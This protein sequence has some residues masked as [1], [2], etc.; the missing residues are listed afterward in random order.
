MVPGAPYRLAFSL[1]DSE[2]T[3]KSASTSSSSNTTGWDLTGTYDPSPVY[4]Y[5]MRIQSDS[6]SSASSGFDTL[7]MDARMSRT[8]SDKTSQYLNLTRRTRSGGVDE[9][10]LVMQV[11]HRRKMS[12]IL[13]FNFSYK[14]QKFDSGDDPG[15]SF[16]GHLIESVFRADF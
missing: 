14:M 5:S 2:T 6:Q 13:T 8:P 7:L 15:R 12:E 10:D 9:T 4:S 16:T 1:K 3:S 11:G